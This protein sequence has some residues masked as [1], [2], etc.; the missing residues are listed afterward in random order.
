MHF[1]RLQ[2]AVNSLRKKIKEIQATTVSE[3]A[4][5]TEEVVRLHHNILDIEKKAQHFS[6]VNDKIYHQVWEL[7]HRTASALLKKV[8]KYNIE[9]LILHYLETY[10]FSITRFML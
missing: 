6:A 3:R 4:R 5:L 9:K 2:D 7:N 8:R 10:S 1:L